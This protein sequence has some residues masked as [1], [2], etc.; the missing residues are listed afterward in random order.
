MLLIATQ[1]PCHAPHVAQQTALHLKIPS[2][3]LPWLPA[4]LRKHVDNPAYLHMV[5]GWVG[6]STHGADQLPE[7]VR[8]YP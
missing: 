8:Q 7:H 2:V 3:S 4:S 1:A 5:D 6:A